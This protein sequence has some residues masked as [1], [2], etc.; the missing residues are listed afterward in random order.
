MIFLWKK[1]KISQE[2]ALGLCDVF[3]LFLLAGCQPPIKNKLIK[4][5][6]DPNTLM[7]VSASQ[8]HFHKP[9]SHQTLK[10]NLTPPLRCNQVRKGLSTRRQSLAASEKRE[11]VWCLSSQS[12]PKT[13]RN[14]GE[15][16]VRS[17]KKETTFMPS[18]QLSTS[19]CLQ[20]CYF[21][22]Q[23]TTVFVC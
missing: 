3:C 19:F 7:F 23:T 10:V 17:L 11:Q 20:A 15:H 8:Y 12:H 4:L 6:G 5:T 9:K 18:L 16:G 21:C 1:K 14:Q 13:S 22:I 2:A